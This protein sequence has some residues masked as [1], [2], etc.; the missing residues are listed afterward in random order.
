MNANVGQQKNPW[1]SHPVVIDDIRSEI[2]GV[3]TYDFVFPDRAFVSSYSF[4]PGQFNMLYLPGVGEAAISVSGHPGETERLPHT[5]RAAGNVTKALA[6][7]NKGSEI[8]LRGPFGSHWPLDECQGKDVVLVGGGI[9]LAPLRPAIYE[10]LS[11]R[12]RYGELTLLYGTRTPDNILYADEFD[13]WKAKGLD[14]QVTVDRTSDGWNGNVGV[15]TL[16]VERAH[17][18]QPENTILLCC[19][20]EVMMW[21]TIQSAKSRGLSE[22]S[23]YVSLERNMNCAIGLCGHCQFG[24]E[25][26]CKDGPVFRYDRVASILKVDD[27]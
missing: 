19:G 27:L 11:N 5:I 23:L 9:G 22:T 4:R 20:P 18:P 1:L 12:D 13:R 10:L 16:L 24:P 3:L 7:L 8:G 26:V 17:L 6:K 14:V 2:P 21:Y 15:V 25:F